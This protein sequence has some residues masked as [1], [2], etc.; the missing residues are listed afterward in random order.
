MGYS[1]FLAITVRR[2]KNPFNPLTWIDFGHADVTLWSCLDKPQ[3]FSIY[4]RPSSIF[5]V[6]LSLFVA[7]RARLVIT[8]RFTRVPAH[9]Q[10]W[11]LSDVQFAIVKR[12]LEGIANNC[13][14]GNIYYDAVH[15]NCLHLALRCLQIAGFNPPSIPK[16]RICFVQ[17]IVP[18]SFIAA[19]MPNAHY[20]I[21]DHDINY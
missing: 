16:Q 21:L 14:S 18:L 5:R 7:Q 6:F 11:D 12:Y 10:R 13:I 4:P 17:T 3:T 15:F 19:L 20:S 2:N 9:W 8:R 1:L